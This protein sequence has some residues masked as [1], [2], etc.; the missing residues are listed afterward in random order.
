MQRT[1]EY[2]QS[3]WWTFFWM[4]LE[5]AVGLRDRPEAD[6]FTL[7]MYDRM[8]E[9]SRQQVVSTKQVLSD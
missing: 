5:R 4:K 3:N 9:L 7:D 6:P 1:P 2:L 8:L